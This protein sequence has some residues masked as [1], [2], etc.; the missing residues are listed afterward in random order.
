MQHDHQRQHEQGSEARAAKVIGIDACGG[1]WP[2]D[3]D[4][5]DED[6]GQEEEGEQFGIVEPDEGDLRRDGDRVLQLQGVEG[7][8]DGER[9]AACGGGDQRCRQEGEESGAVP[10]QPRTRRSARSRP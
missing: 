9:I 2:G 10:L 5:A 1:R 3:E 8:A 4:K 6:A 7:V